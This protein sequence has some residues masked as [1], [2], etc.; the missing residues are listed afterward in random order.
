[1]DF[2]LHIEEVIFYVKILENKFKKK[3]FGEKKMF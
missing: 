2:K 3:G 1:M